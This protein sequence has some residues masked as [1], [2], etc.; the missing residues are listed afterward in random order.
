MPFKASNGW[1]EKFISRYN[2]R[3]KTLSGESASVDTEDVTMWKQN[4]YMLID[5]YN[6]DDIFNCDETGLY[7]KVLHTKSL[8]TPTESLKGTK[9]S[10]ERLT[11]LLCA[12][13]SG[14]EKLISLIIGKSPNPRC[15]KNLNKK[16]KCR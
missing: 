4:L 3:F 6:P 7:Y 13:M 5:D 9:S 15:F 8:V 14:S 2:I 10:K 12:N 11:A 16:M 1:L